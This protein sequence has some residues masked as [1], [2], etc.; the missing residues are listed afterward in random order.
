MPP[1]LTHSLQPPRNAAGSHALLWLCGVLLA[2]LVGTVAFLLTGRELD[3]DARR[4]F[5]GLAQDARQRLETG[6]QS[7]TGVVRG[8]AALFH[9]ADDV[10]RDEFRRYVES[11][12]L[13]HSL[14]A[15]DA[16]SYAAWVPGARR[17]AFVHRVRADRSLDPAGYPDFDIKPPGRREGYHVITYI[18]PFARQADKFGVD[19]AANPAVAQALDQARDSGGVSASGTPVQVALP[20]PHIGLGMRMPVYRGGHVPPDLA[21]RRAN[22]LGAVGIGFSVPGLVGHALG[23]SGARPLA[24]VLCAAGPAGSRRLLYRSVGGADGERFETMLPVDFN[25]QRWEAHFSAR[26]ADMYYGFDRR[27]P[28]LALASGFVVT[29]LVYCLFLKLYWS[30]RGAIEQRALLDAVLDNIDAYVYMKDRSRRYLYVNARTAA[31][32]GRPADEIV[33][34]ADREVLPAGQADKYWDLDQSVFHEGARQAQ[35][36][37]FIDHEGK[38]HQVWNVQVPVELDGEVVAVLGVSADVTELHE[39]KAKAD[40]ASLAKS[41]FLSNM[42]HEI[43]TPMN[44]I[45]G[46]THLARQLA[47]EPK[48]QGYLERIQHAGQHLLGII[49]RLLDFSKIEAGRLELEVL[50]LSLDQLM[51]N[52]RAQLEEDAAAKGLQLQFEVDPQLLRPMRGDPL[53]LE[54]VLLNFTGNAIKFSER[55]VVAVRA[56][57]LGQD[58][59]HTLVRF[60]VQDQG[61]GIVD[62]ELAKLFTPFHQADASITRRHGGTGLGLV[63]SKQLAELMGGTVGV[64]SAPGQ[65]SLFWFT[66]RLGQGGETGPQCQEGGATSIAGAR[67]LLVEDNVFNQEVGRELLERAGALVNVAANGSEALD[68]LRRERFDCVLMDLQMPV[69]DGLE[70]TRRI[71]ADAGLRDT[72]VIAMT[73]NA[74]VEDRTRCLAAGMDEFV[75]KP[76]DPAQLAETIARCIGRPAP[77]AGR[78]IACESGARATDPR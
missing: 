56:R 61:M 38:A 4:R 21:S 12:D 16:V 52:V 5:D 46:M 19:I 72:V 2:L 11:L 71:R 6:I 28:W 32:F 40:A 73:A 62:A 42:S 10:R 39:L 35:Q 15:I 20:A 57:M 22:Y 70:A 30:R 67:I 41:Q 49:N 75:T 63:I 43:R 9:A 3:Q 48:L 45:I 27:I 55:G 34:M 25:G 59:E 1:S 47:H 51:R 36:R 13:A 44:S 8:L 37:Q 58:G 77:V 50:D 66:A 23:P 24:L 29:L 60:E 76:V 31:A 68:A 33:G 26:T 14:P 54:Q 53:R 74:S 69:M 17:D 78:H 18:E 65:G 7:Y 64:E